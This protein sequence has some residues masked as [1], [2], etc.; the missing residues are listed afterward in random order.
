MGEYQYFDRMNSTWSSA[1]CDAVDSTR[2]VKMDCH[3]PTTHFSLLGYFKEPNYDE[4][5]EQLFK[6]QGVCLWTDNE[7]SQMDNY[8]YLW[9]CS[10]SSIGQTDEEGNALEGIDVFT[11][12]ASATSGPDGSFEM[13]DVT[14]RPRLARASAVFFGELALS[15][16]VP[17]VQ[18]GVTDLGE[19]VF[20][21]SDL[22]P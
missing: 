22:K 17:P 6:H 12:G 9:P 18:G 13:A 8:R 7:Y 14:I 1:A 3:L 2:C 10:C 5:M 21:L 11:L 15:A 4:W 16:A 20:T 19:I